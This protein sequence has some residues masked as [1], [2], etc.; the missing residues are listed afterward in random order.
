MEVI[1]MTIKELQAIKQSQ[2]T[3]VE[4]MREVYKKYSDV[5]LE[6]LLEQIVYKR[7]KAT[8][9]AIILAIGLA[10]MQQRNQ[11]KADYLYAQVILNNVGQNVLKEMNKLTMSA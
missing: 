6:M 7:M 8:E 11:A 4:Q 10:E 3:K 1:T 2:Q 9:K 5:G